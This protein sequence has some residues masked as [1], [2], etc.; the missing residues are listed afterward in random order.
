MIAISSAL[1]KTK[2]TNSITILL[3]WQ[4]GSIFVALKLHKEQSFDLIHH[5]TFASV[6]HFSGCG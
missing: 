1:D 5:I 2:D 3:C 4:I 6:R